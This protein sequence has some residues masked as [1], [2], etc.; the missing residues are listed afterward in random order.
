MVNAPVIKNFLLI[1]SVCLCK[2][3]AVGWYLK[4]ICTGSI[5]ANTQIDHLIHYCWIKWYSEHGNLFFPVF[6]SQ[7]MVYLKDGKGLCQV[8][9]VCPEDCLSTCLALSYFHL[10]KILYLIIL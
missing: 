7:P 2:T 6:I 5:I 10:G 1:F 4:E 8:G 3:V 9:G